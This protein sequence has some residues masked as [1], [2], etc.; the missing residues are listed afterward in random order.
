MVHLRTGVRLG[1][2]P[3]SDSILCD[4]LTDAFHSYH[5]G[6]TGE[7]PELPSYVSGAKKDH[8]IIGFTGAFSFKAG[9]VSY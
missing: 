4:G 7:L 9:S 5:M 3:L 2:T 6:I 8:M 1:E